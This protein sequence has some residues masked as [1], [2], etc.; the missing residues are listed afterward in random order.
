MEDSRR[1]R[2]RITAFLVANGGSVASGN[3]NIYA[4]MYQKMSRL[5]LSSI[6]T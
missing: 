4:F 3:D 6:I 5:P 2:G 1:N